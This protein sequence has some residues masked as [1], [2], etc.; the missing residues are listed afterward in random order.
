LGKTRLLREFAGVRPGVYHMAD[1]ATER[2][3]I[4]LMAGSMAAG[5]GEATLG[6]TDFRD[7]YQLFAAYDRVRP[8]GKSFLILDEYQYLCEVQP[9]FSS[10]VQK[11]WDE[12]WSRQKISVVLCGSVL[13][14][15][16]RETISRS[17]PL[18]GRRTG[19]ILLRPLRFRH[20]AGFF[21]GLTPRGAI[22][23]W[24]LT[25]GV[26]RYAES[27]RGCRGFRQALRECVFRKEAPL[28]AEARTLLQDEVT[29]TSVFWS[30][31]SAIGSGVARVSEIA[32]RLGLPANQLTRYLAVLQDLG[33]IRREVPAGE[34]DPARSKRG[35]YHLDDAFLRLWFG[36]VVPFESLLEFGRIDEAERLMGSRLTRHLSW[37]FEQICR[38]YVEDRG[39][40]WGL[41]HVGRHW[42]RNAEVDIVGT[43]EKH[44][45]TFAAE[46]KW[47]PGRLGPSDLE[48]LRR[49]VRRLWPE[50]EELI[51]LAL[52][53]GGGFTDELKRSPA[54]LVGPEGL[55]GG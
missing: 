49:K 41:I 27:V 42:D 33:Y 53:S 7:W 23:M 10:F 46:C 32:G 35:L 5:L 34:A 13:S 19:Q 12:H 15:M 37:A 20:M 43:D 22:E 44:G 6:E 47:T 45:V 11:W 54:I 21:P 52:F 30:L 25:G 17:S 31:L 18:Y 28:Y 55:V 39:G 40:E 38:Q 36:A 14:S 9:A 16:H 1:R 2:D 48:N 51:R 4:R 26:P 24:A 8:E 3:A 29:V 50:R